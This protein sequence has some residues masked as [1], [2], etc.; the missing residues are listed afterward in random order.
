MAIVWTLNKLRQFLIGIEF[1]VVT[2]CQAF[3]YLN[4]KKT[5][6]ARWSNLIQEYNFE[7]KFKPGVKMAHVDAFSRCPV[8]PEFDTLDAV[9]ENNLEVYQTFTEDEKV[10]IMQHADQEVYHERPKRI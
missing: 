4:T 8:L 10:L 3:V 2:D 5:Q 7:V 1:T 6:I 9:V